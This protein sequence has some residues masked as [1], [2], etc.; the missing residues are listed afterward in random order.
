MN[1]RLFKGIRTKNGAFVTYE[2]TPLDLR[3]DLKNHSPMG[4]E[5]GYNGSGSKQLALAILAQVNGDDFALFAYE[6]F[7]IRFIESINKDEWILNYSDISKWATSFGLIHLQPILTPGFKLIENNKKYSITF[8]DKP[9]G[10]KLNVNKDYNAG[11]EHNIFYVFSS[12]DEVSHLKINELPQKLK[13][14]TL[15]PYGDGLNDNKINDI[16]NWFSFQN[17]EEILTI[18]FNLSLEDYN[19]YLSSKILITNFFKE[20]EKKFMKIEV[21]TNAIE[22][23]VHDCYFS[24]STKDKENTLSVIFQRT[25]DIVEETYDKVL[26]NSMYSSKFEATF[27]LPE[28]YQSILKPYMLYFEEFLND[29]CIK[30]DV[31]IRKKGQNTILFVEPKNKDEALEKIANASKMYLSAPIVATNVDFEQKLQMQVALQKLHAECSHM[32]SQLLLKSAML[33]ANQ[34]QL[35]VQEQIISETKRILV[36]VGVKPEI[37][38]KNSVILLESLKEVKFDNKNIKKRTFI[39]SFK[40]KFKVSD[41]FETSIEVSRKQLDDK[42]K[43]V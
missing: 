29:L 31:S 1:E 18:N 41:L 7:F 34:Q 43:D 13:F 30:S 32:E 28:E 21:D 4:F 33:N 8:N 19:G 22:D 35:V 37:I 2:D 9:L 12:F 27:N 42:S 39:D 25:I 16:F 14:E 20:L 6:E 15:G 26:N 11:F 23:G 40:G 36:E 24:I 5:W 3:L 38:T 10:I 17:N